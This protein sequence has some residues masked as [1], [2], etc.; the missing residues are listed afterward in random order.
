MFRYWD[1]SAWSAVLS[2]QPHGAPPAAGASEP[3]TA[4][5]EPA[6]PRS[7]RGWLIA[8]A[9]IVVALVV[10]VAFIVRGVI[11]SSDEVGSDPGPGSDQQ[12][13]PPLDLQGP[14]ENAVRDG[15]VYGGLLSYPLLTQP[16]SP[17]APENRI[18]Y[19]FNAWTQNIPVE[20]YTSNG[21]AYGWV[22]SVMIGELRAGDGFF[23]PEE[24]SGI[25]TTC[26]VGS[27][28]GDAKVE[29]N[30]TVNRAVQVDGHDAWLV[31]TELS[32]SIPG[33]VTE[34]EW[35]A[36]LIVDTGEG[37]A[38][39]FSASIPDTTPQWIAPARQAMA[40]L[41]VAI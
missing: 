9:A 17:P 10:V 34:G 33:L 4:P 32:F 8:G 24:G 40:D 14:T 28:Y 30:D 25:V 22:A 18:P 20:S 2:P 1:G 19:G 37:R 41:Q 27:F 36:V 35:L 29:R 26:I 15:R 23:S 13:C 11:T 16:W 39:I 31:E 3:R 21:T 7:G 12:V 6:Q 5:V 38:S